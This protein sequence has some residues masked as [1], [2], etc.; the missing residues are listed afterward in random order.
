MAVYFGIPSR[1]QTAIY[2]ENLKQVQV[3]GTIYDQLRII[4]YTF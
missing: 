3:D 4:I 2:D 1:Y